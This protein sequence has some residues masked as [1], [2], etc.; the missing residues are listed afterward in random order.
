MTDTEHDHADG[1]P[2]DGT[3]ERVQASPEFVE[4]RRRL[5][6]FVFPMTAFFLG[7]YLLY[8]LLADYAHGFMAI[9]L[10]GNINVG[11]VFGLLQFVST[12][13]ITGLY[14]RYANR[15]LDPIADKI[16]GEIEEAGR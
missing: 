4:L 5:R 6:V 15:R 3:W 8:V 7:W 12:F 13:V 2:P 10:V 11:L 9:K 16:R 14:V 1:L